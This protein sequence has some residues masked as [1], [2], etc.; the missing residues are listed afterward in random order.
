MN[1]SNSKVKL[2]NIF[3]VFARI[4]SF[5]LGGGLAM[6]P[7]LHNNISFKKKWIKSDDFIDLTGM[8]QSFPGTFVGNLATLIGFKLRGF[9]GALAALSGTALAPFTVM[10]I[11]ASFFSA[12]EENPVVEAVF[13]GLRPAVIGLI[14][15]SAHL[16]IKKAKINCK[17]I[18][19]PFLIV[20]SIVYLKLPTFYVMLT[21][22]ILNILFIYIW[23]KFK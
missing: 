2:V 7:L 23:T 15:A 16:F 21:I 12:I 20:F 18:I 10:V 1:N 6:I 5:T 3:L 4:S 17:N 8:A 11:L 19:I 9:Y 22:I 13:S 14:A